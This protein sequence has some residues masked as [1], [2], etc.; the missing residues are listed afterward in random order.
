MFLRQSPRFTKEITVLTH[1]SVLAKE[2]VDNSHVLLPGVV[3]LVL[4]EDRVMSIKCEDSFTFGFV[5]RRLSLCLFLI[6]LAKVEM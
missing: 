6:G 3:V 4:K 5:T 1:D 2:D